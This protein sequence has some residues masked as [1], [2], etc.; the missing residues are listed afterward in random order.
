M[1]SSVTYKNKPNTSNIFLLQLIVLGISG[2]HFHPV[3]LFAVRELKH[4]LGR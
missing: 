3:I 4:E 2:L 1:Y